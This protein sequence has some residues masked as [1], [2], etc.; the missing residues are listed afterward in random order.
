MQC[1]DGNSTVSSVSSAGGDITCE[2]GRV[3]NPVYE[4]NKNQDL[5][6]AGCSGIELSSKCLRT[7]LDMVIYGDSDIRMM[8]LVYIVPVRAFFFAKAMKLLSSNL[9]PTCHLP[10]LQG[11]L[12]FIVALFLSFCLYLGRKDYHKGKLNIKIIAAL[13]LLYHILDTIPVSI[14]YTDMVCANE[15]ILEKGT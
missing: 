9:P 15:S 11:L 1:Y 6:G 5:S 14:L 7:C 2:V 12:G 13:S 3:P 4:Q 10:L 8:W